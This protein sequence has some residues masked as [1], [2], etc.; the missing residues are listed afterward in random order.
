M[1]HSHWCNRSYMGKMRET[2]RTCFTIISCNFNSTTLKNIAT[3]LLMTTGTKWKKRETFILHLCYGTSCVH[4]PV[5]AILRPACLMPIN[6]TAHLKWI[7][8]RR[9][10]RLWLRKLLSIPLHF[11]F[12]VGQV[13]FKVPH[14]SNDGCVI[15]PLA[16]QHP[17]N[18][19]L[20]RCSK[21][22]IC[23]SVCSQPHFRLS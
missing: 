18:I 23:S 22:Q 15:H 8:R 1:A 9:N 7:L 10:E 6:F 17:S 19:S 2:R 11:V 16:L 13:K 14:L 12:Q 4:K 21:V 5:R 20:I 3:L